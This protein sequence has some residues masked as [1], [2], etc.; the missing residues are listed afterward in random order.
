M[1]KSVT[2]VLKKKK[3]LVKHY[4]SGDTAGNSFLLDS[5][6]WI[7]REAVKTNCPTVAEKPERKALNGCFFGIIIIIIN[8]KIPKWIIG[9]CKKTKKK[10]TKS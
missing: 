2:I 7:R 5:V 1:P 8:N 6:V 10:K 3:R 4:L 9:K